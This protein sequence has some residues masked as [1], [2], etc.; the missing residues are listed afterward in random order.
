MP[1]EVSSYAIML[2][3]FSAANA[4]TNS[5]LIG[6][7]PVLNHETSVD[8]TG[9]HRLAAPL[10]NR[11]LFNGR[12]PIVGLRH[13]SNRSSRLPTLYDA[14]GDGGEEWDGNGVGCPRINSEEWMTC[15]IGLGG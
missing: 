12:R 6:T 9:V 14:P 8:V 5:F 4:R 11:S 7:H 2:A 1:V 3:F 15:D 10:M 13:V